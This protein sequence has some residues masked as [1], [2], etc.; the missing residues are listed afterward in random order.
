[1]DAITW[2]SPQPGRSYQSYVSVNSN[3]SV[4]LSGEVRTHL[5]IQDVNRKEMPVRARIG[6]SGRNL[7]IDVVPKEYNRGIGTFATSAQFGTSFNADKYVGMKYGRYEFS[8]DV[9]DEG[10]PRLIID[11]DSRYEIT[12]SLLPDTE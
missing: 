5:G 12:S 3:G 7:I 9:S 10:F 1:M 11:M 4:F 2:L 6:V 8:Y